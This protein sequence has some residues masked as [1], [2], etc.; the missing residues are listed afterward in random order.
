MKCPFLF[1]PLMALFG[2]LASAQDVQTFGFK[3][4]NGVL[5]NADCSLVENT[6]GCALFNELFE[7][8]D[9]QLFGAMLMYRTSLA[10][11][12]TDDTSQADMFFVF[13]LSPKLPG[14]LRL[15]Y[16]KGLLR[17]VVPFAF[18]P[19]DFGAFDVK[20]DV[21]ESKDSRPPS[22][23]YRG[24]LTTNQFSFHQGV[25]DGRIHGMNWDFWYF[26]I[27]TKTGRFIHG[28]DGK[29]SSGKCIRHDNAMLARESAEAPAE[30]SLPR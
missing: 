17:G 11:F 28:V 4:E 22:P 21:S 12:V 20:S 18:T 19:N 24:A 6:K 2:T 1:L 7:A 8:Q 9:D 25:Y 3:T 16:G 30:R 29:L 15:I 14:S 5:K 27:N 10:C 13:A 23:D 26:D